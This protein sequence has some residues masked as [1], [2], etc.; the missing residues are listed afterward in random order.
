[1]THPTKARRPQI[2][3]TK[4]VRRPLLIWCRLII[5]RDASVTPTKIVLE[6][7]RVAVAVHSARDAVDDLPV[8]E[9]VM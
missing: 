6:T 3:K 4:L 8:P 2:I 5:T 1:M 7:G 9:W